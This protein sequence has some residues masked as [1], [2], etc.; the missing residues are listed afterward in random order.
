MQTVI[1]N[2]RILMREPDNYTARAEIM[3]QEASLTM[4]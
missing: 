2:A 3:W 1:Y 4:V